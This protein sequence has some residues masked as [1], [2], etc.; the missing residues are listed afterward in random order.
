MMKVTGIPSHIM[1]LKIIDS[2][3]TRSE[4]ITSQFRQQLG[5]IIQTVRDTIFANDIQSGTLNLATLKNK[6]NENVNNVEKN[7]EK[8]FESRGFNHSTT[9]GQQAVDKT[10]SRQELFLYENRFYVVPKGFKF[11]QNMKIKQA[12]FCWH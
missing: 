11:P 8:V 10:N 9:M 1:Q 4:N 2:I 7:V 3:K 12:W 6:L 5:Q